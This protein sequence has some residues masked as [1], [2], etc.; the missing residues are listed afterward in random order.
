MTD[1]DE[2]WVGFS[3]IY[4]VN[5]LISREEEQSI[6]IA[7]EILHHGEDALEV[8]CGVRRRWVEKVDTLKRRVDIQSH[9]DTGSIED[10]GALV[11]VGSR[12]Q[13]IDANG[14]DAEALE[15]GGIT[16][17]GDWIGQGIL[18]GGGLVCRRASN[19]IINTDHYEALARRLVD[20]VLAF[21][22]DGIHGMRKGIEESEQRQGR[23]GELLRGQW[24]AFVLLGR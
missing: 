10:G 16:Q 20:E 14:V 12:V 21:N 9:V 23:P 5:E 18:L 1:P 22:R 15:E 13:V 19:L 24:L 7:L 4:I 17:T 11:V 6:G 3:G 2:R 8:F